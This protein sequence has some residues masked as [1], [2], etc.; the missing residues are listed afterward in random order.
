MKLHPSNRVPQVPAAAPLHQQETPSRLLLSL[1]YP[2]T[3]IAPRYDSPY[4]PHR[5]HHEDCFQL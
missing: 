2:D 1:L 5:I 4:H 3:Y